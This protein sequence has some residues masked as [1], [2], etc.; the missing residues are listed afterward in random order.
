MSLSFV[1]HPVVF[2]QLHHSFVFVSAV[3]LE[4][5]VFSLTQKPVERMESLTRTLT[6]KVLS[7]RIHLCFKGIEFLKILFLKFFSTIIRIGRDIGKIM[8]ELFNFFLHQKKK[9]TVFQ[10]THF[11][12]TL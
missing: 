7:Q 4:H 1:S 8:S 12:S 2:L 9:S 3:E 10:D 6:G 5:P 11:N